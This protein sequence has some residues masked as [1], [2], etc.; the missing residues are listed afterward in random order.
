MRT[1]YL[2]RNLFREIAHTMTRFLSIF[3]ISLIGVAFFSGVRAAGPDMKQAVYRYLRD[4]R[5]ADITVLSSAG[6]SEDDLDAIRRIRGVEYAEP[7]LS[8]DAM[9]SAGDDSKEYNMHLISLPL[10]EKEEHSAGFRFLP[11]YGICEDGFSMNKPEILA[12]RLPEDDHEII[13]DVRMQSDTLHIG[14]KVVMNAYGTETELYVT[15]FMNSPKYISSFERGNSSVG[16]GSADGFAYV[17][18]NVIGSLGFKM[19]LISLLKTRYSSCEILVEGASEL[20]CFGDA[21]DSLVDETV[22]RLETYGDSTGATW[23]VQ[24]RGTSNPGYSDYAENTERI[25][26]VGTFFP[27]IFLLVAMLVALTTMTR[28]VEDQ[29]TQM[30]TLKAI[31][32]GQLDI[33][34]QY[35]MYAILASLSGSLIGARLGFWI[36]P[37]VIG[38]AYSIMYRMPGFQ[39]DVWPDIARDSILLIVGGVTVSAALV[40]V[41]AL[42]EVPASLMRPKAP[43]PG[44]RVFLERIPFLWKRMKFTAKVTARNLL[45]YKK[46]F[47]MCIIGIAGSCGLIVTGFGLS[48][49][50]F[51]IITEQFGKV[52]NMTVQLY[53]YDAMPLAEIRGMLENLDTEGNFYDISYCYD[54]TAKG[55]V[56]G[57]VTTDIH[58]FVAHDPEEFAK[59]VM[60]A[61]TSGEAVPLTDEGVL[62]TEKLAEN[63]GLRKGDTIRMETSDKTYFAE[64]TGIVQNYVGH[65]VYFT[66]GCYERTTGEKVNYNAAFMR[67][68]GLEDSLHDTGPET[69]RAVSGMKEHLL[70]DERIYMVRFLRDI[71]ENIWD[72]LSVLNYVVYVLIVSAAALTF[73][74]M[75]N[76]T[77]INITERRREL[78]TLRVLGFTDKEMYD[79]VFRENNILAVIGALTGLVFGKFMHLFVAKTCEVDMVM[80]V[81]SVKPLSY[82]KSAALSVV[83]ALIVNLLMRKKIRSIDMIESLKSV[84]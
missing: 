26:A 11:E 12:G 29:R 59:T 81:R 64:V 14:S 74:V 35:L 7:V 63:H 25:Q 61:D 8:T 9:M 66:P 44:K 45:R 80:F 47:Y 32:Y 15:G 70:T 40:S 42:R 82:L 41:S 51:G 75:L 4:T 58:I 1:R 67:I 52:W 46:R 16:N 54:K 65:Y 49:S 24:K 53:S 21:Y 36:F 73:V 69:E 83:F 39:M 38:E 84:D 30:G 28:M 6:I 10:E 22:K 48:D 79:Y 50:V 68:R 13:L 2:R 43:K 78:A 57:Q 19:P 56:D 3:A 17:S 62:I 20:N 31:G 5:T 77:N 72:S 27:L 37:K 23:Y 71:Y 34:M 55:G 18:G 76:L 33:V 60:L